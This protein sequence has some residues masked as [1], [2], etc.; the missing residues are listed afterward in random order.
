[1][2]N[3][4]FMLAQELPASE[5]LAAAI[6][7]RE[8]KDLWLPD[9]PRFMADWAADSISR[10]LKAIKNHSSALPILIPEYWHFL[11]DALS[12]LDSSFVL[13]SALPDA[14]TAAITHDEHNKH[15]HLEEAVCTAIV[16]LL[17]EGS[18]Y[19]RFKLEGCGRLL[20]GLSALCAKHT[21]M[22]DDAARVT[23][24]RLH[25]LVIVPVNNPHSVT[26][27]Y[28]RME[29]Q[30]KRDCLGSS[31]INLEELF[32]RLCSHFKEHNSKSRYATLSP[33]LDLK[34]V[35]IGAALP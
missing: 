8:A 23:L 28:R 24:R 19:C 12:A 22:A 2:S 21:R 6:A 20:V 17:Q 10:S 35:S 5:R 18:P 25:Q 16:P 7:V 13:N 34:S 1:M 14:I 15:P 33:S 30:I 26:L 4:Q 9:K 3:V 32:S 31:V 11:A 29:L 27:I